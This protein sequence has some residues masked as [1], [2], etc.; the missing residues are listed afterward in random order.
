[1]MH[2]IRFA[3]STGIAGLLASAVLIAS[4]GGTSP[5]GQPLKLLSAR[6][7]LE[8]AP[9]ASS[10]PARAFWLAMADDPLHHMTL[11]RDLTE[12]GEPDPAAR[13]LDLSASLFRW[14]ALYVDG[15]RE[16]RTFVTTAQRLEDVAR[17]LRS[18][19]PWEG[20]A[21]DDMLSN[22]FYVLSRY[23]VA[24]ALDQWDA[25]EYT[26]AALLL[27]ATADEVQQG[28]L[29]SG[30]SPGGSIDRALGV[31]RSAAERLETESPPDESE[32]RAAV[33]GLQA[34]VTGLGEA[35]DEAAG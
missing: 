34:G 6:P 16:R 7:A 19:E 1:M 3:G 13:Q 35:L 23:H 15:S 14:G 24:M 30:A 26:R 5:P 10:D 4:C 32:V 20:G 9:E 11:A 2:G 22:A 25:G 33:E 12:C 29:L 21:L 27:R 31:A 28:F 18:G 8:P 17:L